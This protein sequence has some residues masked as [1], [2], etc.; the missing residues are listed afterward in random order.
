MIRPLIAVAAL[1]LLGLDSLAVSPDS[2]AAITSSKEQYTFV[3]NAKTGSVEV[4]HTV[5]NLYTPTS[6]NVSVP[7]VE[8]Y[9][10]EVTIDEADCKVDGRTPKTFSPKY[11]YYTEDDIFYSDAHVCYFPLEL[12]KK[13][14]KGEVLFKETI[15]DPRYFN[16]VYLTNDIA[17]TSREVTFTIPRWMKVE[18]KEFNFTGYGVSKSTS[19]DAK[20]D[21]DVITYTASNIPG[22][23]TEENSPGPTYIYPHIL[24]LCKSASVQGN[25]F[26]Y[27]GT[28]DDQYAWYRKLVLGIGNNN[29]TVAAKAKELTAGLTNDIDKVKAVFYYVQDNIRYIAFEN[30]LAGFKPER[31]DE[32]LRKKYGDCKGMA[33]L[34]KNLLTSLGF[35]ARLCWLGTDHIAYDYTT[36]SMAVD[37]HMICALNYKGKT[38][39][40]DATE[41]YLG[42]NDYAQRIQGRPILIENG[43]KYILTTVPVATA[44]Q[45]YDHET[46]KLT[47]K[48]NDLTGSITHF[49]KGEDKEMILSS[50]NSTRKENADEA[51]TKYLSNDNTDYVIKDLALSNTSNPDK[52]VTATYNVDIK[53]G[54][55]VFSKEYYIDL[56][57]RKEFQNSIIKADSRK[58]DYWFDFKE[59]LCKET[60]LTVPANYKVAALPPDLDI[61]DNDY[62]FHIKYA[63]APGKITY[64]KSIIIKNTHLPVSK[65]ANWNSAIDRLAKAYNETITLKPVNQ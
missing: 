43:D 56:D 38:I 19:Y 31:A 30:G 65:F 1:V 14:S 41:T 49:W 35:D 36:P 50:M 47:I 26:A 58:Y 20:L 11:S 51:M 17:T 60:E 6:Y 28:L 40:L 23:K 25:N 39:F 57:T 4:K 16:T 53:N 8:M 48:D 32:V 18:L 9:N 52:D 61:V 13:D 64:K 7:I 34:T 29:E 46:D 5:D 12:P 21:A 24:V 22:F 59:N 27:L 37:N 45:N 62:E 10:D 54:V 63:S 44:A 3:Y 33:N 15:L 55:S 42:I 2:L